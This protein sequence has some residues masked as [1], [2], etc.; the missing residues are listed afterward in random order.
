MADGAR[1]PSASVCGGET[2][3]EL[4]DVELMSPPPLDRPMERV[5]KSPF[6]EGHDSGTLV[7]EDGLIR[8]DAG[9]ELSAQLTGLDDGTSMALLVIS[10]GSKGNDYCR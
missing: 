2:A 4:V 9:V 6:I 5:E 1:Y 3:A 8:V 7:G 10:S